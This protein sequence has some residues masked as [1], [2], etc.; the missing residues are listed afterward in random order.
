VEGF[1]IPKDGVEWPI[2]VDDLICHADDEPG[3]ALE[4]EM[5]ALQAKAFGRVSTSLR[6]Y[7]AQ[8][9]ALLETSDKGALV[10]QILARFLVER[11]DML[12]A[13]ESRRATYV[14][15]IQPKTGGPSAPYRDDAWLY[16]E[17]AFVLMMFG[18]WWFRSRRRAV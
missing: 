18:L 4:H 6:R 11:L 17:I 1:K 9:D 12:D 16:G 3:R 5:Y 10:E 7:D 8:M 2:P 13:A 15:A 14:A